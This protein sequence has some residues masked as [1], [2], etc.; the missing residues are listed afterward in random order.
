MRSFYSLKNGKVIKLVVL[1]VDGQF[2]RVYFSW[3]NQGILFFYLPKK[4]LM[5]NGAVQNSKCNRIR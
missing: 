2:Q 4:W 5:E 1:L 3:K